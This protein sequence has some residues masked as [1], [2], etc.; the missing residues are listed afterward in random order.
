MKRIITLSLLAAMALSMQAQDNVIVKDGGTVLAEASI[1]M[2]KPIVTVDKKTKK[3]TAVWQ[4]TEN[5]SWHENMGALGNVPVVENFYEHHQGVKPV[6]NAPYMPMPWQLNDEGGETVLHCYLCMPADIVENLWLASDEA[7][8]LD[9]ETGVM[10]RSRRTVPDCYGKVFTVRG[11]EGSVADLQV[12]FPRLPETTKEIAIYGVPNW[13]MRGMDVTLS[14]G[15]TYHGEAIGFDQ[16][17]QFHHPHLVAGAKDYNKDDHK[18][19]AVYDDAHLIKPT[20]D[21]TY[22]IWLTPEAT[23]LAEACEMNWNR[24]Y[25]GRGGNTILID[26]SGHQY[27]CLDVLDY[28]NDDL[29]WNEGLSGDYF[30]VV[31]VFEPLPLNL[32]T[33]TLVVPEGEPFAMWGANWSGKVATL[34]IKELRQN[35]RLFDYH[36]REVVK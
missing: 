29:F 28:P 12:V 31:S 24:E 20:D 19:W 2:P 13:F 10:Y 9:K 15:L 16:E 5:N 7:A 22:A 1:W 32:E 26:H 18:T 17:P 27:K 14:R 34:N 4:D 25:F 11:K 30:A 8:I 35:Q 3:K 23:Y 6:D 33:I 36:P 21:G